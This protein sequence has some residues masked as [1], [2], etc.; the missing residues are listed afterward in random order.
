M[1]VLAFYLPWNRL[2][3]PEKVVVV[4]PNPIRV[5]PQQEA[6]PQQEVTQKAE[7]PQPEPPQGD[8]ADQPL[9]P[10]VVEAAS[11]SLLRPGEE[12][13]P[14]LPLPVKPPS[15]APEANVDTPAISEDGFQVLFYGKSLKGWKSY[16]G[17]PPGKGWVVVNEALFLVGGEGEDLITEQQFDDFDLEF[18]WKLLC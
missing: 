15:A 14:A 10:A 8:S 2:S 5:K 6:Q 13:S 9:N 7:E 11:S 17:G 3:V 18:E 12:M 16:S 1:A 4:P